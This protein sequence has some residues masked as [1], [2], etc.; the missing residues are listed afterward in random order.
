MICSIGLDNL[1]NVKNSSFHSGTDDLLEKEKAM[2]G[3]AFLKLAFDI[4]NSPESSLAAYP[5]GR[6]EAEKRCGKFLT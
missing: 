4:F 5:V 2:A 3:A 1:K 6:K